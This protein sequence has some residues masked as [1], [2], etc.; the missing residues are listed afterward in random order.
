MIQLS[1]VSKIFDDGFVALSDLTL[2]ID[3]GEFA[4]V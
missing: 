1:E 4:F 3:K 2:K